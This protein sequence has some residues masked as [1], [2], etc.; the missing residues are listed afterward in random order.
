MVGGC[1]IAVLAIALLAAAPLA[2]AADHRRLGIDEAALAD[3]ESFASSLDSIY[4]VLALNEVDSILG[5]APKRAVVR[6]D[7][8]AIAD[9]Y[10][11][12]IQE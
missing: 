7:E 5:G 10:M 11:E 2:T 4:D 12:E 3:A 1:G 6:E 9:A 8:G